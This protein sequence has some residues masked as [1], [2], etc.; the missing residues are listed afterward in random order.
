V[1]LSI[2]GGETIR[3]EFVLLRKSERQPY[4]ISGLVTGKERKLFET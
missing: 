3:T 1:G 4:C 2:G